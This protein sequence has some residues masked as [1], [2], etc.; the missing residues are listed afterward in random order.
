LG[1]EL[2]ENGW[3]DVD[4]MLLKMQRRFP[5]FNRAALEE[6]IRDNDKQRFALSNDGSKIRASQGHSVK[7]DLDYK[8]QVPPEILYHG[9]VDRH[10][11]AIRGSGLLKMSRHAVHLSKDIGTATNVASRYGKPV[12]LKVRAGE[13]HREGFDFFKSENG[14][15]LTDEVPPQFIEFP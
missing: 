7:V 6:V 4:G 1:I 10:L 13:M 3:T 2:D 15:W 11:E 9:T 5:G 12:L 14:V 8:P